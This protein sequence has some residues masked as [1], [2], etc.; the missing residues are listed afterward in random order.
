M[1]RARSRARSDLTSA[2]SSSTA[3][4]Y[5]TS[6][7][8]ARMRVDFPAPF[9]P[10][11]DSHPPAATAQLTPRTTG[12]R[13]RV[14]VSSRTASP[15]GGCGGAVPPWLAPSRPRAPCVD[16]RIQTNA[17]APT[18]AVTTPIGSSAG[19]STVRA[20][21]SASTRKPPPSSDSGSTLR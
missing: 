5:G 19:D 3:P 7:A 21:V 18:T 10:I 13:S 1:S 16:R 4:G 11:S 12:L 2:P 15:R 9:G 8:A 20:S 14:T 6:P 17:G